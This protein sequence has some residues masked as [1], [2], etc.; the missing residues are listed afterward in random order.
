VSVEGA[1]RA[2]LARVLAR[3]T[4]ELIPLRNAPD[5]AASLPPGSTI[6]VTASPARG[7]DATIDLA[8]DLE[9]AGHRSIPHLSARMIRDEDQL[10]DLLL[11][12][13]DA[14]IDRAFVVGG[15]E[16]EPGAYPDA[17]SLLEAMAALGRLPREIGVGCYPQGHPSI[18]DAAL[19]EALAA[20][21]RFASYMTTQLC[22][23]PRAIDRW[24]A[25]RR[26]DGI[27]LPVRLGIPGVAEIPRLLAIAARIGVGDAGRFVVKNRRFVGQLMRSGGTYRPTGLLEDL[28]PM[29]A[30]PVAD[31][32]AVHVFTFNNASPSVDW[33]RAVSARLAPRP[34]AAT[35]SGLAP[36]PSIADEPR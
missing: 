2:G 18:P 30:D 8:V 24:L 25:A 26:A 11:R 27:T 21:A 23:D 33:W 31:V 9:R 6:A 5:Q 10:R 7:I 34:G 29:V 22:F 36:V 20:K 14:G 15:D 28:G 4:W 16:A 35:G 17:L 3:V 13:E 32:A 19:L 12:L 1:V